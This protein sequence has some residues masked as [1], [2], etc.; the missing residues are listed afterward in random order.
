LVSLRMSS[1]KQRSKRIKKIAV[2]AKRE[3]GFPLLCWMP[4]WQEERRGERWQPR[5]G[6]AKRGDRRKQSKRLPLHTAILCG[7]LGLVKRPWLEPHMAYPAGKRS[8][9]TRG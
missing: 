8:P 7:L 5:A 2:S 4:I 3:D 6:R 1:D 9:T